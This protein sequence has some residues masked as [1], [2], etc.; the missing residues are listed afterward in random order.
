MHKF[1]L[2][3]RFQCFSDTGNT[4]IVDAIH[5]TDLLCYYRSISVDAL[6]YY[7]IFGSATSLNS[8]PS[9]SDVCGKAPTKAAAVP[10]AVSLAEVPSMED[11][12]LSPPKDDSSPTLVIQESALQRAERERDEARRDNEMLRAEI[13][14]MRSLSLRMSNEIE[15]LRVHNAELRATVSDANAAHK[16]LSR[17]H[18]AARTEIGHLLW[19]Y[20]PNNVER[21]RPLS[22]HGACEYAKVETEHRLDEIEIRKSVWHG[23]VYKVSARTWLF[24]SFVHGA[25]KFHDASVVALCRCDLASSSVKRDRGI[26]SR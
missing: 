6:C 13:G 21:F 25:R 20:L 24:S 2:E 19:T 8:T 9:R 26:W 14:G 22:P 18:A 12:G 11:A 1:V 3:F 10:C 15:L 16:S 7:V 5:T 23:R 4:F 17:K